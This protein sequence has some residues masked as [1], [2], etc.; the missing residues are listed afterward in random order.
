MADYNKYQKMI[1]NTLARKLGPAA[2]DFAQDMALKA[3]TRF[4]NISNENVERFAMK[5]EENALKYITEVEAKFVA[6]TIRR[7]RS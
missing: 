2:E 4:E 1:L 7:L 5:V 6:N 3:G